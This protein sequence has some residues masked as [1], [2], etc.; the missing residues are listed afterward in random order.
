[1]DQSRERMTPRALNADVLAVRRWLLNG[2]ERLL[3]VNFGDTPFETRDFEDRWRVVLAN[4]ADA[5]ADDGR[6]L[7]APPRSAAIFG[8][9]DA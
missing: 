7:C 2:T 5:T 3:L 9:G 8:R 4:D 6:A 1:M